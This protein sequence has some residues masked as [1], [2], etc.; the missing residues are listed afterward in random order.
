MRR[1]ALVTGGS[2]GIGRSI[3]AALARQGCDVA[4]S[5]SGGNSQAEE[6]A[7]LCQQA[8]AANGHQDSR[9]IIVRADLAKPGDCERLVA[10]AA[11]GI[12][13]P[14][15]LINNAGIT[16]DGLV[17]RMSLED[18][19]AVLSVNLR[20]AFLLCKASVRHMAKARYG[21]IV[22]IASVV[23]IC[24]NAGQ[25]NYAA[26]KAG[27]IGLTKSLAR[28]LGSRNITVN[29]IAPGFIETDMTEKLGA[30]TRASL[31]DAVALRRPGSPD[32]VAEAVA[33]LASDAAAY[34]TGQVLA[35]DGGMAY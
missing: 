9:F 22:N 19:D 30:E 13:A 33:F 21:R 17:A 31:L 24:G 8:A 35:V 11:E 14:D 25:A 15:I 4:I 23:G 16:R 32:D 27:L 3:C 2:R 10:E 5:C 12:G 28:E 7:R 6:T 18:F 1:S 34:I 20:A 29:A 26:S